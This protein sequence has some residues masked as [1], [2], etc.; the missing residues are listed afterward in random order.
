MHSPQEGD[1]G[2][3][4][5]DLQARAAGGPLVAGLLVRTPAVHVLLAL[6]AIRVAQSELLG[7]CQQ[8]PR[9]KQQGP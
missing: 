5:A 8:A 3:A 7:D 6:R 4:V 1:D 2:D 9:G